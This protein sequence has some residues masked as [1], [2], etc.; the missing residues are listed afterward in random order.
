VALAISFGDMTNDQDGTRPRDARHV[1]ANPFNPE[2]CPV[3]S[4]AVF[5]TILRITDSKIFPGG[6]HRLIFENTE[7]SIRENRD[8]FATGKRGDCDIGYWNPLS[9]ERISNFRVFVIK[10]GPSAAAICIKAGWTLPGVQD[11]YIRD[12]SAGVA[13]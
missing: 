1:Y 3:L 2:I 10:W 8:E 11:T 5:A 7:A 13:L 12:E 9:P 6:N 4:L